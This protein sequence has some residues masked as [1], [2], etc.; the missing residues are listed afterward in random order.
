MLTLFQSSPSVDEL[1]RLWVQDQARTGPI[2]PVQ[3]DLDPA[4]LVERIRLLEQENS[5]LQRQVRL[6]SDLAVMD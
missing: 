4:A 2:R 3:S 5:I 6:L 1:A